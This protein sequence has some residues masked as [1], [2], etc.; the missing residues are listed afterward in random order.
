[1]TSE[2]KSAGRDPIVDPVPGDV[3]YGDLAKRRFHGSQAISQG[4]NSVTWVT[5]EEQWD[6]DE[7]FGNDSQVGSCSLEVWNRWLERV[8]RCEPAEG[9]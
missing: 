1:M 6:M 9:S 5:F 7:P 8:D 2:E 3:F 4:G